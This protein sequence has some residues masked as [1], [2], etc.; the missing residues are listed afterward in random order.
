MD[1]WKLRLHTLL[2]TGDQVEK[3]L[4]KN[5][6]VSD[7][8]ANSAIKLI[9]FAA[10]ND[11]EFLL[12]EILMSANHNMSMISLAILICHAPDKFID[13]VTTKDLIHDVLIHRDPEQLLEIVEYFKSKVFSKGFGS[14]PQKMI[15]RAMEHWSAQ[16]LQRYI[17][18]YTR[19]LYSLLRLVHPRYKNEKGKMIQRLLS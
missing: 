19:S 7:E 18:L 5:P 17:D 14:R 1:N 4:V 6:N 9:S 16:T 13:R 10:I 2:K 15:R 8:L 12:Q 3:L 11:P